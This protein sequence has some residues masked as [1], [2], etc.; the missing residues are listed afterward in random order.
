VSIEAAAGGADVPRRSVEAFALG[1]ATPVLHDPALFSQRIPVPALLTSGLRGERFR[2]GEVAI[3]GILPVTPF[4]WIGDVDGGRRQQ[5][6]VGA[7]IDV[8]SEPVPLIRLP[9]VRIET[10]FAKVLDEPDRG[11][12]R[13]WAAI[14]MSP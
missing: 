11:E 6:L 7:R 3:H 5:R 1:G 4:F 10:G 13:A 9:G 14:G 8:D 12:W 2:T